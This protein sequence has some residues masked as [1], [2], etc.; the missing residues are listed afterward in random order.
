MLI[1]SRKRAF[2]RL[3][4]AIYQAMNICSH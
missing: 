4:Q 3:Q 2:E 1:A